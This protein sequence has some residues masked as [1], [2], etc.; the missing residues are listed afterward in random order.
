MKELLRKIGIFKYMLPSSFNEENIKK[1]SKILSDLKLYT[2]TYDY[3][4]SPYF[5]KY[6]KNI[7][8]ETTNIPEIIGMIQLTGYN[9]EEVDHNLHKLMNIFYLNTKKLESYEITSI[10]H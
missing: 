4:L 2:I 7:Y 8:K 6:I 5:S 3:T 1:R 9:N 10:T